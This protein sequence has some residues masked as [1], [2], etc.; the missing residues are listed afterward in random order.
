MK[1]AHAGTIYRCSHPKPQTAY[2]R[3]AGGAVL[4]NGTLDLPVKKSTG[5]RITSRLRQEALLLLVLLENDPSHPWIPK[6]VKR[7]HAERRN[8]CWGSTLDNATALAALARYQTLAPFEAE[9]VGT[10]RLP[11]GTR[12]A[13]D[14]TKPTVVE[15]ADTGEPAV[16]ESR[17]T[18]AD[19][20][21]L[22]ARP[23]GTVLVSVVTEGLSGDAERKDY[24]RQLKVRRRW[25]DLEGN[26]VDGS[27]LVVGDLVNVETTISCPSLRGYAEIHNVAIVDAL[28]GGMEVE[29]PRL[30]TSA[31]AGG[32]RECTPDHVEFLD[33]RVVIF[34]SV[35]HEAR[36]F[37]YALRVIAEGDFAL[38]PVQASCMYD[39]DYASVSSTPQ[40]PRRI[41][42]VRLAPRPAHERAPA[43]QETGA[44]PAGE[45]G[46]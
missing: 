15:F 12:H 24:D 27:S 7:V 38:P 9:Y 39:E 32:A 18:G 5:G 31:R 16:V 26:E 37:R 21:A 17:G 11:D 46:R 28:A 14:H 2:S 34:S 41:R 36:T 6:L 10:L 40:G 4:S 22:G 29:N 30:A 33:D 25:L 23:A 43:G 45:G 42:V 3:F 8:G 19:P 1:K 13:F 44:A 35:G 20:H